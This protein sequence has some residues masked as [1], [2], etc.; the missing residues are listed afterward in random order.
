MPR[1]KKAQPNG[2]VEPYTVM[3]EGRPYPVRAQ[4]IEEAE[5]EARKIA[6][7]DKGTGV[8][9]SNDNEVTAEEATEQEESAS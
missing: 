8:E 1:R 5:K 9:A 7:Q 4:S 6:N 2:L 3:I